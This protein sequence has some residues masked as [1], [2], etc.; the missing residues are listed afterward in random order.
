M[1]AL[2]T[3]VRVLLIAL[4][5]LTVVACSA[6]FMSQGAS[7][8]SGIHKFEFNFT[9][10]Q[11]LG[12]YDV[13]YV[14]QKANECKA[15]MRA[16]RRVDGE[17]KA[18]VIGHGHRTFGGS[19]KPVG[20]GARIRQGD[21]A[22][23]C[24]DPR[25]RDVSDCPPVSDAWRTLRRLRCNGQRVRLAMETSVYKLNGPLMY[26]D[27]HIRWM[28]ELPRNPRLDERTYYKYKGPQRFW[29]GRATVVED[30]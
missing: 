6:S 27:T 19:T 3:R 10:V 2:S 9:R 8:S 1:A 14:T 16:E 24:G 28:A 18:V 4:S 13:S 17:W 5:S 12:E 30:E 21:L 22:P 26:H 7:A 11:S 23:V 20:C 29:C 25:K 15:A